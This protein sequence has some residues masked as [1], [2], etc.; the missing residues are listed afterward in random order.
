[1]G[2]DIAKKMNY[3]IVFLAIFWPNWQR[4]QAYK[5]ECWILFPTALVVYEEKKMNQNI[6]GKTLISWFKNVRIRQECREGR[7]V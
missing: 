7:L 4:R 1:M 2:E 5:L 3:M 6:F